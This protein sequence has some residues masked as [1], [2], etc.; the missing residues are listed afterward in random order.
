MLEKAYAA[1]ANPLHV[2]EECL[3]HREKRT[4]IDQVKLSRA[5]SL[6]PDSNSYPLTT[7]TLVQ[8]NF[9]SFINRWNSNFYQDKG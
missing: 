4:G 3:L 5:S 2:A 6:K 1:T 9:A 8:N 7:H